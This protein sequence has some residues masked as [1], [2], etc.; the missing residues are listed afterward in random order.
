[1][2]LT[3]RGVGNFDVGADRGGVVANVTRAGAGDSMVAAGAEAGAG[4]TGHG[5]R[6][7][8]GASVAMTGKGVDIRSQMAPG[9]TA[10]ADPNSVVRVIRGAYGWCHE[11]PCERPLFPI[12]Q[13]RAWLYPKFER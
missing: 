12:V 6:A 1:M 4:A 5:A 8:T 11:T 9:R 10:S 7:G 13:S 2:R 3:W